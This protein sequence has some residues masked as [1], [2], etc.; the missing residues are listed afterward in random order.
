MTLQINAVRSLTWKTIVSLASRLA[1]FPR[2]RS[3]HPSGIIITKEK[4]TNYVAMEYAK[5]KG[6]GLLITQPDMYSTEDFGLIKIDLLSQ[7]SLGVLKLVMSDLNKAYLAKT[8]NE[9]IEVPIYNIELNNKSNEQP[10][11]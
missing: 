7:R 4:I 11:N 6:L 3:I 8:K 2:H 9:G 1:G 5:N 10:H